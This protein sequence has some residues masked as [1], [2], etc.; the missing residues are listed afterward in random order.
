MRRSIEPDIRNTRYTK[1]AAALLKAEPQA[2]DAPDQTIQNKQNGEWIIT[3]LTANG[4][5]A[6]NLDYNYYKAKRSDYDSQKI[7][8]EKL[9]KFVL[10]TVNSDYVITCCQSEDPIGQ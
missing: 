1:T 2:E 8:L 6:F 7:N 4:Q 9:R 10:T 3:D 5:I